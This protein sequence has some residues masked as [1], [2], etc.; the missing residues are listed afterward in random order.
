MICTPP[1]STLFPYTTLFR[2]FENGVEV[3]SESY[4]AGDVFAIE[5]YFN[6]LTKTEEINYY[7]NG[8]IIYSSSNSNGLNVYRL[9]VNIGTKGAALLNLITVVPAQEEIGAYI[10]ESMVCVPTG[11][12][13]VDVNHLLL[14]SETEYT[15][16]YLWSTGATTPFIVNLV[17]GS[18]TVTVTVVPQGG[19]PVN[20]EKVY[21]VAAKTRWASLDG[22]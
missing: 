15:I 6:S 14:D 2:S 4:E 12:I 16:S 3:S 1:R 20:Y 8:A 18:Y 10:E 17:P 9:G 11:K 13:Q 21:E 7:H 22:L 19:T 5:R